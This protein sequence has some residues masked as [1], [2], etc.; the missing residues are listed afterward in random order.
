MP[1]FHNDCLVYNSQVHQDNLPCLLCVSYG[2]H[3]VRDVDK[4]LIRYVVMHQHFLGRPDL[5]RLA[6]GWAAVRSSLFA[7]LRR[8]VVLLS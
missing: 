6:A 8:G 1:F 3:L 7:L 4:V 2:C 5:F